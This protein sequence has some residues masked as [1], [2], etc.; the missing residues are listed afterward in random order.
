MENLDQFIR[1]NLDRFN[2]YEPAVGH[3]DRFSGKLDARE[4]MERRTYRL[5]LLRIAALVVFVFLLSFV[6]FREYRLWTESGRLD[7][8]TG[9]NTEVM[10]A[11][12]Y[13]SEQ[14]QQYYEQI[15]ELQ[16]LNNN[17]EKKQ[18]LRELQEMDQ[19]VEIMKEDLQQYPDNELIINAIMNFYQIKIEL[20]NDIISRVQNLNQLH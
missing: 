13:Y 11:E 14:M 5:M 4:A 12:S 15:E 16:F 19:Q 8:V 2:E 18:V 17:T 1:N 10:E 3:G 7:S 20:M 9:L 6:F